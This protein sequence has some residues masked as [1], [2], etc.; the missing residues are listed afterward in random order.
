MM[1]SSGCDENAKPSLQDAFQ[2]F[3][4]A[5]QVRYSSRLLFHSWSAKIAQ[6]K[7]RMTL[8]AERKAAERRC[9]PQQ[10]AELRKKFVEKALQYLGVPYAKKFHEPG[11]KAT[12]NYII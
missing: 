12:R 1:L 6:E 9:D 8:Q 4:K 10:M 11:S 3:R 2:R 5:K 7:I